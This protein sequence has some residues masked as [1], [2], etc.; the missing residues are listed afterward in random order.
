M[1][2]RR[3]IPLVVSVLTLTTV[4]T[5]A[6]AQAGPPGRGFTVMTAADTVASRTDRRPDAGGVYDAVAHRTFISWSGQAADTYVQ[7]YD[8]QQKTW[9][10]PKRIAGGESDSHNYPTLIEAADGHLLVIR[11]MHNTRT[12]ISRA[13]LAHSI[14]GTWTDT[15]IPEGDAASYPMPVKTREGTLFVFYRETTEQVVPGAATDFR[16]MKYLVSKDNGKTWTNSVELTGKPWAVGSQGR[17][18]HMD[19]IYVGQLRY[20]PETG[21]IQFGYTLAGGGPTQ[22]KH[23]VYHRNVYYASF[24]TENLH[25]Y[26][27]AGR[28]LGTQVDDPEQEQYLKVLE[29]PIELPA[30]IKSPDY[31]LQVGSQLGGKPFVTWFRFD[32]AGTPHDFAG[33]WNGRTWDIREVATGLRLREIEPLGLGVWRVYATRDNEPDIE[34]YLLIGGRSWR[35][36]GVITTSKPV[37]RVEVIADFRDPARILATGASTARDVAVADGDIYV[38]GLAH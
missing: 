14:D 31:I 13:P 30:N 27:A 25:F 5:T 6:P 9:T 24:S 10:T 36:E 2:L 8:H 32:T 15:E 17:A 33:A 3:L 18:D 4:L 12:V 28:D 21:R 23:D 20:Q 7:A 35:P 26:S 29:T 38:A 22:H 34:T 11:G 37:Q 1:R 19:E 16:P